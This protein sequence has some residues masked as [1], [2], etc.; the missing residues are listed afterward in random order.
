MNVLTF[1][2]NLSSIGDTEW[3]HLAIVID[4]DSS[5]VSIY[6]NGTILETLTDLDLDIPIN[7]IRYL[8]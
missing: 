8:C 7:D 6:Q 5:N 4:K 2:S 1:D 3:T